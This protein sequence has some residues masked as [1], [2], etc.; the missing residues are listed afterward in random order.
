MAD[1]SRP[2]LRFFIDSLFDRYECVRLAAEN[3]PNPRT[4]VF[5]YNLAEWCPRDF[6]EFYH[7]LT[8]DEWNEVIFSECIKEQGVPYST[9]HQRLL[10]GQTKFLEQI[11]LSIF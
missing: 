4:E 10:F 3:L 2:W 7:D 1:Y 6:P 11:N 5:R 9:N 8:S